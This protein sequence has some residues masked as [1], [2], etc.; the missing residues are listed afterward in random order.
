[1]MVSWPIPA[2]ASSGRTGA[3][4]PPAL[5]PPEPALPDRTSLTAF[6]TNLRQD[7]LTSITAHLVA[8][9]HRAHPRL[10]ICVQRDIGHDGDYVCTGLQAHPAHA[11]DTHPADTDQRNLPH[12]RF[13]FGHAGQALLFP[14]HLLQDRRVNRSQSAT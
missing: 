3:A 5:R 8:S 7:D 6:G 12:A 11:F 10:G 2:P 14:F 13:P 4:S 9:I 1:M